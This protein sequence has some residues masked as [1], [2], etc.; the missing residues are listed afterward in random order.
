LLR[1]LFPGSL[2]HELELGHPHGEMIQGDRLNAR[3]AQGVKDEAVKGN[4]IA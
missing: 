2:N 1:F 4:S 3:V